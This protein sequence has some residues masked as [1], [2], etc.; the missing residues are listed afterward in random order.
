VNQERMLTILQA[1]HVSEKTM[2]LDR[3]YVFK[4]SKDANK[5]EIGEAVASVFNVV[6][7]SVR[8]CNMKGKTKRFGQT[9][10][11]RKSWKKAYVKLAEGSEIQLA[12][13]ES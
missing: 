10:G 9:T 11:K 4:V 7:E 12:G 2:N 6:V 13:S 3:Q 8:V 5:H 1:P